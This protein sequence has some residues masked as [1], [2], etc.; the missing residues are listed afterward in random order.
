MTA[1]ADTLIVTDLAADRGGRRVFGRVGFTVDPGGAVQVE[2]AN[3]AGKSTLLRVLAG[4]LPAAEGRIDNPFVTALAGHDTALKPGPTLASELTHWA[5]LDGT[6]GS[7]VAAAAAAFALTPLLEL[8]AGFLSSGQRR[9]AALARVAAS[10]AVL[11][12]LDEPDAGLDTASK[13]LLAAAIAAHRG[14]G[15][16][17]VAVTHGDIGIADPQRV[18]L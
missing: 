5:R 12:L 1:T 18:Q 17:V 11:W 3:G 6:D 13:A 2:G 16:I 9:R 15:G 14:G 4:L 8:P 10:G 7:A